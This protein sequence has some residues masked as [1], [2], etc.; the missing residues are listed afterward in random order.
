MEQVL[1]GLIGA[2]IATIL[3]VLYFYISEQA[4]LRADA[5][6]EV[7]EYCDNIYT[8]LRELLTQKEA[9]YT[10][11]KAYLTTDEYRTVNRQLTNLLTSSRTAAKITLIYGEG[12]VL[13]AFNALCFQFREVSSILREATKSTWHTEKDRILNLFD[14]KIDPHRAGTER[15]LLKESSSSAIMAGFFKRHMP[16]FYKLITRKNSKIKGQK[17]N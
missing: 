6:L 7:V 8:R 13:A 16:T 10:G 17:A 4:K 11:Q 9:E 12:D 2:L 5:M 15:L 14:K 1:S 3:S